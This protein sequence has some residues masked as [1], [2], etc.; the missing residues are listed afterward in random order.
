MTA[1]YRIL[2]WFLL[3]ALLSHA[4]VAG[5]VTSSG[6]VL[7]WQ[8]YPNVDVLSQPETIARVFPDYDPSQPLSARYSEYLPYYQPPQGLVTC[9][10]TIDAYIALIHYSSDGGA[11]LHGA[12]L[13]LPA[14]DEITLSFEL[15]EKTPGLSRLLLWNY[16]PDEGWLN[17]LAQYPNWAEEPVPG[18][19]CQQ[20]FSGGQHPV[21]IPPWD[22]PWR[23]AGDQRRVSYAGAR[24]LC[25]A[26]PLP[27]G[28]D[29]AK[30]C[31]VLFSGTV[32]TGFD[33]YGIRAYWE[34]DWAAEL[35]IVMV[36]PSQLEGAQTELFLYGEDSTAS[37]FLAE[38]G[39]TITVNGWT[40]DEIDA[41]SLFHEP[42]EPTIASLSRYT[43]SG[44]NHIGLVNSSF[45]DSASRLSEIEVWVY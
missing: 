2:V 9:T 41:I 39:L 45:T 25:W 42:G 11:A 12:G 30:D 10:S 21:S 32:S 28:T 37:T 36:L 5:Q 27:A 33:E 44:V 15:T 19:L 29:Q 18:V 6:D 31:A 14:G 1:L 40:L 43:V 20:W 3:L 4:G 22:D 26:K 24:L 7:N 34:L 23:P 13:P 35:E 8:E 38:P 16:Q 17:I